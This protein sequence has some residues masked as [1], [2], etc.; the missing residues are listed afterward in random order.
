MKYRFLLKSFLILRKYVNL[1]KGEHSENPFNIA[2]NQEFKLITSFH[3]KNL[4]SPKSAWS[5]ESVESNSFEKFKAIASLPI[6][7]PFFR[8]L[9]KKKEDFSENPVNLEWESS[10]NLLK[11]FKLKFQS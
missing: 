3:F 4:I 9:L 2:K 6:L 11:L 5:V 8:F 7:C 1:K 10:S